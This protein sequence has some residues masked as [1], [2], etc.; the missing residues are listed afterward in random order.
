MSDRD[1]STQGWKMPPIMLGL[2]VGIFLS[3]FLGI[4]IGLIMYLTPISE[5]LLPLFSRLILMVSVFGGGVLAAK[6]AGSKGLF[7]GLGVAVSFFLVVTLVSLVTGVP[8]MWSQAGQKLV[9]CFLAG[10]CGGML[11][12]SV[13]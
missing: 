1:T 12:I 13:K 9:F 7:H 4:I 2:F 10:A 11:G 6:S 8:F 5:R 3:A